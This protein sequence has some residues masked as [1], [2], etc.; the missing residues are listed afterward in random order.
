MEYYTCYNE[1]LL[2]EGRAIARRYHKMLFLLLH[3]FVGVQNGTHNTDLDI[4]L[5]M[6]ILM[7]LSLI[8]RFQ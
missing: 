2:N 1:R 8:P 4:E 3:S 7:S 6:I 5:I